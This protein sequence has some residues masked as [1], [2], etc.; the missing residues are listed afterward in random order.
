MTLGFAMGAPEYED[1]SMRNLGIQNRKVLRELGYIPWKRIPVG[2]FGIY[3]ASNREICEGQGI[4]YKVCA[5]ELVNRPGY[6][7]IFTKGRVEDVR[8]RHED[9]G[10]E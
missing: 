3:F 8:K 5:G 4:E 7:V 10:E 1:E 6:V 9:D 2:E